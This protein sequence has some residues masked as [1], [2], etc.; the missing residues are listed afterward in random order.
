MSSTKVNKDN[1]SPRKK[2]AEPQDK[3]SFAHNYLPPLQKDGRQEQ[4]NA[5]NLPHKKDPQQN[6][7]LPPL[8]KYK[9]SKNFKYLIDIQEYEIIKNISTGKFGIINLV[10]SR[11]TEKEFITKTNL[12]QI[13]SQHPQLISREINILFQIQN[14]SIIQYHG[15]SFHD[16]NGNA[17][18][19]VFMDYMRNGSLTNLLKKENKA[20]SNSFFTNTHRQILITGI[21]YGMM[22]LHDHHI[23]HR[24]L[25]LENIFID[26]DY[27]PIISEFGL[28]KIFDP[29]NIAIQSNSKM[30]SIPYLAPE[31]L[32]NCH[33]SPK[34]DVYSFGVLMHEIITGNR[35][36]N[37]IIRK[38]KLNGND[39]A[40]KIKEGLRLDLKQPI[41]KGLKTIIEKCLSENPNERPT[42]CEIFKKLSLSQD[43]DFNQDEQ[44]TNN[45]E[46]DD[47]I[48][49]KYCLDDVDID[50]FLD[51]VDDIS[52]VPNYDDKSMVKQIKEMS[53][54]IKNQEK[55]IL[56]LTNENQKLNARVSILEQQFDRS[57]SID[58]FNNIPLK[59]QHSKLSEIISNTKPTNPFFAKLSE[60]LQFLL[61]F[62]PKPKFIYLK[63]ISKNPGQPFAKI[64]NELPIYLSYYS[65]D[66]LI[67]NK[68]FSSSKFQ[69]IIK[70]FG[71]V[72]IE[73]KYP[74]ES[75][76]TDYDNILH[77]KNSG[78]LNVKI[79]I[80]ISIKGK[81]DFNFQDNQEISSIKLGPLVTQIEKGK[82]ELS[83]SFSNCTSL[84][85]VEIS[86]SVFS[87]GKYAFS[88]CSS[89]KDIEIPYS[90]KTIGESSFCYCTS[91]KEIQIPSSVTSIEKLA[92]SGCSLIDEIEIPNS[93]KSIGE[94]CFAGC[95]SLTRIEFPSN[96]KM[97]SWGTFYGC[98]SLK[99]VKIPSSVKSIEDNAFNGCCSLKELKLNSSI[100]SIGSFAF[101]E[102]SSLTEIEIP[103]SVK[104]IGESAFSKCTS[105]IKIEILSS[106]IEKVCESTFSGC[107]SLT[108]MEIP[109]S[110]NSIENEAFSGCSSL[111][112]AR[113]PSSV[114]SIGNSAFYKCTS[115]VDVEV[116]ENVQSIGE[117]CFY[118]CSTL[119]ELKIPESVSKIG[120]SAFAHCSSLTKVEIPSSL[121]DVSSVFSKKAQI[122]K[123]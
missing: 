71:N 32:K 48:E 64:K 118:G 94:S 114:I 9:E 122:I 69:N 121:G 26:K 47:F 1:I 65:T 54:S 6:I 8:N 60:I 84:T 91:L 18:I 73:L 93:V 16:F 19:T 113:I 102:C 17:N 95:S 52:K 38:N 50:K 22:I 45:N 100:K 15:F 13:K 105:L 99:E 34:S 79:A 63:I 56:E 78:N 51:Y 53:N 2:N 110:V 43:D 106:T 90:I 82:S 116:G 28:T 4:Q 36:Y 77:Y 119:G 66:L 35:A 41:K 37:D 61:N 98:C 10:K 92:F 44:I 7:S 74:S 107:S 68:S 49:L 3:N 112:E 12:V 67:K 81:T 117:F 58:F 97:I 85:S 5:Q 70:R 76:K 55:L 120:K 115:I 75:F 27:K 80:F 39:L 31:I 40:L 29:Q 14:P 42:F 21:S 33:F 96:L 87:I 62:D 103:S 123:Y 11:K 30:N 89:L 86:T 72:L 101:S 59:Y 25:K 83:G 46:D 108:T 23:I 111:I 88:K 24:D 20:H 57:L 109:S 104:T